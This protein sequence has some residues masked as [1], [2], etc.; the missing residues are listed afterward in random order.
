MADKTTRIKDAQKYLA[1]GQID[2][3][4]AE[5]EKIVQEYPDGHNYNSIGD[6]YLKK[7]DQKNAIEA[8]HK[9]ANFFRQEGFS[10]KALALFKKVLNINSADADALYALG[11]LSEEKELITDA[12]KYYLAAADSLSKEGK[13]DRVFEV[14]EKILSLS[15]S[16]IP[17]RTKVADTFLKQ[18]LKSDAAKEYLFIAKIYENKGD[19]EKSKEYY[20]KTIDIQ[21]LN[22]A[23]VM[24]LSSLHEKAGETEKAIELMREATVLFHGS[25]DVL[26]RAAELS[27]SGNYIENAKSYLLKINEQEPKNADARQLL[28]EIYLKEGLKK[29]AWEEYL[30][31]LDD[32]ILQEKYSDVIKV[33]ESFREI[34]PVETGGRLVALYKQ[35]GEKPQVVEELTA[36]GDVYYDRGT[37]EAALNYYSEAFETAPE[38]D[39]LRQRIAELKGEHEEKVPEFAEITEPLEAEKPAEEEVSADISVKAEKTVDEIFSE[40]D[41]FARYGLLS[42]AQKL[43]EGLR[44]KVPKSIDLHMRLKSLYLDFGD[45]ESA[46]TECL[47]LSE[48]YKLNGDIENSQGILREGVVILPSDPRLTGRGF[49]HL[50]EP[51]PS[52]PA[53][54]VEFI[55]P[56]A[57]E[58]ISIEDYEEELSEADFYAR[59]GLVQEALKILLKLQELFPGNRNVAERLESLGVEAET[60]D[61]TW[62]PGTIEQHE[63]IFEVPEEESAEALLTEETPWKKEAPEEK[64]EEKEKKGKP[65]EEPEKTEYEDLSFSD[66]EVAEAQEMPEPTLDN[67][68]LE[69]FQE[70]KK[71]LEGQLEDEDSETHYNLGIAYKEMGLVDDAI[72]EFQTSR[73]DKKSFLQSSSMLAVCYMEKGL[74]SLAID[75]LSKTLESIKEPNESYWSIKYDLAEAYEKNDNLKDALS[76]YTEVYGWNAKFRNVS[77]KV[78]LLKTQTGKPA[79]KEKPKGRKDRVSYL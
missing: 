15:P 52:E 49:D 47:I 20:R 10:L 68:V 29:N 9:A 43:L 25:V 45:K 39:Y 19:I 62:E 33:L 77:E 3:A 46:V 66:N 31:V 24:G 73:N 72:K 59:Q 12:I 61:T 60:S 71:G 75:V 78:G 28:A 23:A 17:L 4:I 6:L 36:L 11:E 26:M 40:A 56:S 55:P 54:A 13:K 53:A 50:L 51:A 41:I 58:E 21:P 2:K 38:D 18:G 44:L 27:L 5:W 14:Y 69:I 67:D 34:D 8:F 7:G 22:K 16:N 63:K 74:Y 76:L 70:F 79:E 64:I 57:G 48:I 1:K 32:M 37:H 35:L 30:V 65:E 42:E